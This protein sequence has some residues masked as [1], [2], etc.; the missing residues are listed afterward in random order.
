MAN[1]SLIKEATVDVF[2]ET[3]G[4]LLPKLILIIITSIKMNTTPTPSEDLYD[5]LDFGTQRD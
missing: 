2:E 3:G 4:C 1:A 5:W